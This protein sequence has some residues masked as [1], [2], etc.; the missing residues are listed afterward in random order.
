[1]NSRLVTN[2]VPACRHAPV[3]RFAEV[4]QPALLTLALSCATV[5]YDYCRVGN[6]TMK[7]WLVL[8][9]VLLVVCLSAVLAL[10]WWMRPSI[11]PPPELLGYAQG[12][13]YREE[14]LVAQASYC[15]DIF[16][17][18]GQFL[19]FFTDMNP[20][21]LQAAYDGLELE[22]AFAGEVDG[23][24][25]F[26]AINYHTRRRLTIGGSQDPA[27]S[28]G[29]PP[30][31][32]YERRGFDSQGRRVVVGYY[33]FVTYAARVELDGVPVSRNMVE[34]MLQTR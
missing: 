15:W 24:N 29:L 34:V 31:R 11:Q 20:D 26:T 22:Q 6:L 7:C 5:L 16:A 18:C 23:F 17:H 9:V 8:L 21:E 4:L 33:P 19:Y 10:G 12:L 27:S 32:G 30:L 1:M 14:N 25:V 3:G 28:P 13:G 2:S